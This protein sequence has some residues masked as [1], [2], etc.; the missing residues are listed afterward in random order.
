MK[1]GPYL[2]DKREKEGITLKEMQEKSGIRKDIIKTIEAGDF[3]KLP[4]PRYASLL[5]EKYA[6]V[7]RLDSDALLERFSDELKYERDTSGKKR[8]QSDNEDYQYLR[9]V[10]ISFF[11]MIL[12]LFVVWMIL[13]QVGSEAD[14]FERT[15]IYDTADVEED[16]DADP[17]TEEEETA[18]EE[19]TPE[20]AEEE[21][22]E[23][24]VDIDFVG[25]ESDTLFYQI[26]SSEA[27]TFTL[28]GNNSWVSFT[29]DVGNT[30]A[31]EELETG[32]YEIDSEA[33]ELYL[34]LGNSQEFE[35]TINGE[36]LENN[37]VDDAITVYYQFNIETE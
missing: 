13:L 7:L 4:N 32:E 30:Y 33:E 18:E 34:T 5:I 25:T 31:Y 29:D 35:I 11:V 22:P 26:N 8:K 36:M 1:L 28:D 21:E 24:Q 27:L 17:S 2:R 14:V 15:A 37:Q 9:K 6:K 16:E 23:P 19:D 10:F 3:S 12:A 20:E